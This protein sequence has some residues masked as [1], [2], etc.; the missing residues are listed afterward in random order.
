[1]ALVIES[2][3]DN[4]SSVH[5]DL[6]Y[7]VSETVKTADPVT[8]PNYKFIGDVYVG[9]TLVA[10]LRKIQDPSTGIGVFDIGQIVRNYITAT[11]DPTSSGLI[12]QTLGDGAFFAKVTMK[13]GEEYNYTSTYNITVDT[14]RT[15]FNHYNMRLVGPST[16]LASYTDKVA[17]RRP[18][19]GH[20]LLTSSFNL[21]P[22][23][24]TTAT[25]VNVTITPNIGNVYS[26]SF[27]PT[28]NTIQILNVSPVVLNTLQAGTIT[29]G[30]TFY[31][32]QIGAQSYRF[33]VI[34]ESQ[35]TVYPIHFLNK[36]GGF[37]TKLFT[38]VSRIK[39]DIQ[40][41]DFG[42][43]PYTVSSGGDVSYRSSNGVYN[44]TRAVY[45]S[46]IKEKMELNSDLLPDDEYRWLEDL[47]FSPLVYM[48]DSGYFIPI[49]ITGNNYEPKK[50]TQDELTNLAITIE[51]GDRLNA[52]FR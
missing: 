6:I 15:F 37:E 31:T 28:A 52:Q 8:Y 50:V 45:S 16:A 2:T 11:F 27:T 35:Y 9:A 33:Y 34:C 47:M 26:T 39:Y 1:M 36:L 5:G 13:F 41:K 19:V 7:T 38:K 51:F 29:T 43:L 18:T 32:V 21:I 3:P 14:E 12:C 30:T 49:V 24:P 17:S 22:Y 20:T 40:K 46:M 23:F 10:R 44:E 42:K 48:E 25:A 4:Y